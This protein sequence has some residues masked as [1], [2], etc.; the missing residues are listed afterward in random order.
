MSMTKRFCSCPA[1]F[2]GGHITS[3]ELEQRHQPMGDEQLRSW[4][5]RTAC[6]IILLRYLLLGLGFSESPPAARPDGKPQRSGE[7]SGL[8][9]RREPAFKS[10]VVAVPA[11]LKDS[12]ERPLGVRA[13]LL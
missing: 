2:T 4:R 5:L 1:G 10:F 6:M 13:K 12:S 11:A 9:V 7:F 3:S 8:S